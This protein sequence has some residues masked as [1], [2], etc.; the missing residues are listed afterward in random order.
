MKVVKLKTTTPQEIE[1][2]L[3]DVRVIMADDYIYF[4]EFIQNCFCFS[5]KG[6]ETTI[7][8]YKIYLNKLNDLSLVGSCIKCAGPV[9]RYIETGENIKND[10]TLKHIKKLRLR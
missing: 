9:G 5:C 7:T 6:E 8:N 1:I 4:D 3:E 10:A 2:T